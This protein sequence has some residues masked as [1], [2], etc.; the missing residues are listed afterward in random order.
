MIM[1]RAGRVVQSSFGSEFTEGIGYEPAFAI[2]VQDANAGPRV[3][4][5][6]V[7]ERR[8]DGRVERGHAA[9]DC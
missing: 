2:G 5:S 6:L 4:P 7:I 3:R 8:A 9:E 1:W